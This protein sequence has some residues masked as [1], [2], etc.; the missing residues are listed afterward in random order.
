MPSS[1]RPKP[2]TIVGPALGQDADAQDPA[3]LRSASATRSKAC[4]ALTDRS[5]AASCG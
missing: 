2:S 3:A 4:W 5:P 1:V